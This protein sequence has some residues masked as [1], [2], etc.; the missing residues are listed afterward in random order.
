VI[1]EGLLKGAYSL[2]ESGVAASFDS[3]RLAIYGQLAKGT[4]EER[5]EW[6]EHWHDVS[7]R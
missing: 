4:V 7:F 1:R 3:K 6:C 2:V 5:E